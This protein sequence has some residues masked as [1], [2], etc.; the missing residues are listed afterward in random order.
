MSFVFSRDDEFL[1]QWVTCGGETALVWVETVIWVKPWSRPDTVGHAVVNLRAIFQ[2][3][4][5]LFWIQ[6]SRVQRLPRIGIRSLRFIGFLWLS[7][8]ISGALQITSSDLSLCAGG[9]GWQCLG[10]RQNIRTSSLD[11]HTNA[12][13]VLTIFLMKFDSPGR[14]PVDTP[15]RWWERWYDR[16]MQAGK[17]ESGGVWVLTLFFLRYLVTFSTWEQSNGFRTL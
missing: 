10:G 2:G 4:V 16:W 5:S 1:T 12:G 14:P 17:T 15:A 11:G 8:R 3:L 13:N 6:V 9:R 7:T